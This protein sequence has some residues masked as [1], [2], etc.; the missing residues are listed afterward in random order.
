MMLEQLDIHIQKKM[1]VMHVGA[2]RS[3]QLNWGLGTLT[4]GSEGLVE[5][6]ILLSQTYDY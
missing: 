6:C 3:Y 4:R 2:H 1:E 5:V